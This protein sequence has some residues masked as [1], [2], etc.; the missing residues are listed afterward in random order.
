MSRVNSVVIAGLLLFTSINGLFSCQLKLI[1]FQEIVCQETLGKGMFPSIWP[2]WKHSFF[3]DTI[4]TEK[5]G[6]HVQRTAAL[7][8]PLRDSQSMKPSWTEK[9]KDGYRNNSGLDF[10]N[11]SVEN[12]PENLVYLVFANNF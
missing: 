1:Y 3:V 6:K 10:W 8:Q 9:K 4:L 11:P 2:L 7:W 12:N 5:I